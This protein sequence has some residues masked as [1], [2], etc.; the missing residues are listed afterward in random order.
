MDDA[1]EMRALAR[2]C[3]ELASGIDD[4]ETRTS[5]EALADHYETQAVQAGREGGDLPPPE[6]PLSRE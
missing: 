1:D 6:M 4:E 3:R 5:L 2:R